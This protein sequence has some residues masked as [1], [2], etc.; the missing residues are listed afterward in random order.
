MILTMRVTRERSKY[1]SVVGPAIDT[2][3]GAETEY[4]DRDVDSLSGRVLYFL[5]VKS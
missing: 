1:T 3:R 4:A 2:W 5:L